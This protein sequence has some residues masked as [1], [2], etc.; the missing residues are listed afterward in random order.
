MCLMVE[1]KEI[2]FEFSSY[3]LKATAKTIMLRKLSIL[4]LITL[5]A[6]KIQPNQLSV[7]DLKLV[8]LIE[9]RAVEI[10]GNTS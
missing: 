5:N 6:R 4:I 9:N 2:V 3:N 1:E 10:K 7:V 8:C